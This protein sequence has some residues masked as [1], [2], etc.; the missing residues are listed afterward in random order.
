MSAVVQVL[1]HVYADHNTYQPNKL[2]MSSVVSAVVRPWSAVNAQISMMSEY[3]DDGFHVR[4]GVGVGGC[5]CGGSAN[6]SDEFVQIRPRKTCLHD[7]QPDV[8]VDE[9][10]AASRHI[11]FHSADVVV[12]VVDLSM[13][14]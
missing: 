3:D 7:A 14:V 4:G 5:G 2:S 1:R 9:R 10:R 12:A 6:E 13:H 11:V 8:A